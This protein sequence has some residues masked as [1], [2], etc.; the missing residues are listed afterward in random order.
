MNWTKTA[1]V[2]VAGG[3]HPWRRV[4]WHAVSGSQSPPA[5]S[6][7]ARDIA[8]YTVA[9]FALVAVIALVLVL[10]GVPLLVAVLLALVVALPLSMVL[11]R[12]LRGRMAAGLAAARERRNA[13]RSRL[14]AE[15]RGSGGEAEPR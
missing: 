15:L 14:R 11:F 10:A 13:E 8:L 7:L 6:A 12:S 4:R 1:P 9:R 5:G 2:A 3:G